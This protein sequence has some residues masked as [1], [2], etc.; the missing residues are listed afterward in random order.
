KNL[1]SKDQ[2]NTMKPSSILVNMARG[3]IVNESDLAAAITN[4]MIAGAGV[5]VFAKEPI[6]K[7]SPYLSVPKD[8]NFLMAPHMG[9]ASIESR[10][11][12]I[13]RVNKIIKEF[14]KREWP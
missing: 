10:Q 3:G 7:N 11:T 8:K 12:L 5:D 14:I 1:I 9:W 13:N 2:L 6:E 4:D